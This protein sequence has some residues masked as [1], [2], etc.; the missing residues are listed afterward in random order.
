ME[1][2]LIDR[3]G[4]EYLNP[5]FQDGQILLNTDINEIVSIVKEG[6]NAN[7]NDIQKIQNGSHQVGNSKQLDGADLSRFSDG[8]MVG[9]DKLIPTSQQVK[10][11]VDSKVQEIK[12]TTEVGKLVE[13]IN[14]LSINV[15]NKVDK[16]DLVNE[17]TTGTDKAYNC[18][19]INELFENGVGDSLPIGTIVEYTGENIPDGFEEVIEPEDATVYVGPNEPTD[20][21]DVWIQKSVNMLNKN[22]PLIVHAYPDGNT[23]S[24]LFDNNGYSFVVEIESNS[25]Y[26]ITKPSGANIFNI[27]TSTSV[28]TSGGSATNLVDGANNE[29][30]IR[31]GANDKYLIGYFA[32]SSEVLNV[33]ALLNGIQVQKGSIA[34]EY[35]PFVERKIFVRNQNGVYEEFIK[36][37][38]KI[39]SEMPCTGEEIWVKKGKNLYNKSTSVLGYLNEDGSIYLESTYRTSDFISVSP[40]TT[41]F[42][43]A[44]ESIR[45]K[46]YDKNKKPLSDVYN[47]LGGSGAF[48]FT[49]PSN[50]YYLRV[51]MLS[52]YSDT[53]QI[54][55]GNTPTDY[56]DY[57]CKKI[58]TKNSDG[59]YE[60]FY[61]EEEHNKEVYSFT[62]QRVG[63]AV[64]GK[65][66][67]RRVIEYA[68]ASTN[69]AVYVMDD[70]DKVIDIRGMAR[71]SGNQLKINHY[72]GGD[73]SGVNFVSA[74]VA[75]GR[76][77][78]RC[79]S[80]YEGYTCELVLDYTK[81][82]D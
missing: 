3:I 77:Y 13:D 9:S 53:L 44:T 54:E 48:A 74:W 64:D 2:N 56:E 27:S 31:S 81:T 82:T 1:E 42:K 40:N 68:V 5:N 19:Y 38:V 51:S 50:A 36:P 62:E 34:T 72:L 47:D 23:K 28:P 69:T 24:W 17:E 22:N 21:Q 49:T 57:I 29:I 66:I 55:L 79:S 20:G 63:T 7:F 71:G 14:E 32:W 80:A 37:Q 15:D 41:Y 76:V 46:Y 16:E 59:G 75:Y 4:D 52:T 67:Y 61:N 39:S 70:V 11:Y 6:I 18:D 43:S 8:E 25:E 10:S 58:Y 35:E 30:H 73:S 60:E 45:A 33:A 78:S 26:T 65:P 12:D